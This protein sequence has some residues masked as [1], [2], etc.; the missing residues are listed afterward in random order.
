MWTV[1]RRE[2]LPRTTMARTARTGSIC[3]LPAPSLYLSEGCS[4]HGECIEVARRVT[5][6]PS[7]KLD[8]P[9]QRDRHLAM[10][11]EQGRLAWQTS[12]DYGRRSSMETTMGRYKA[13][14]G[15]RLR[16]R[17][18]AAQQTEATISVAALNRMLAADAQGPPVV[19]SLSYRSLGGHL[20]LCRSSTPTPNQ[21]ALMFL[22]WA[23]IRLCSESYAR[24]TNDLG[25]TLTSFQ[26]LRRDL[27]NRPH[28]EYLG[29]SACF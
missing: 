18:L 12:T 25:W 7:D 29:P 21:S 10:I 6:V 28:F 5:A 27:G 16:A 3:P 19:S 26:R 4:A 11:A 8:S 23:S 24:N 17:G 1:P 15:P 2:C 13:L 22:R 14:I 9:T 20:A